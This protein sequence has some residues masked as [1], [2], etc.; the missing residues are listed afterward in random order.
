MDVG[1]FT[2]LHLYCL[3][4]FVGP[5]SA[6]CVGY[7]IKTTNSFCVTTLTNTASKFETTGMQPTCRPKPSYIYNQNKAIVAP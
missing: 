4:K 1:A 3:I 6:L 7:D 5:L 2:K